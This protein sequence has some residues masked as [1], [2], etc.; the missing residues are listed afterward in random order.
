MSKVDLYLSSILL[1][2]WNITGKANENTAIII[3]ISSIPTVLASAMIVLVVVNIQHG[4]TLTFFF[5]E[6]AKIVFLQ[7]TF[8]WN[9]I[10]FM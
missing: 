4:K 3:G 2:V 7:T 10:S 5:I 6:P 9:L 1:A 8:L